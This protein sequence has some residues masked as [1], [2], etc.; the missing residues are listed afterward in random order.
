MPYIKDYIFLTI[1]FEVVAGVA[2]VILN[3]FDG[4]RA[5]DELVKA[6]AVYAVAVAV[7]WAYLRWIASF[8][9]ED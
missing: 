1:G 4:S 6:Y 9:R 8:F 5:F 7:N 2:S 3:I